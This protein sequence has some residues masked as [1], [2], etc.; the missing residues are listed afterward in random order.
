MLCIFDDNVA[1]MRRGGLLMRKLKWAVSI[2]LVLCM[3]SV[4]GIAV[5]AEDNTEPTDDSSATVNSEDTT[6]SSSEASGTDESGTD[7]SSTDESGTDESSTG[8][9]SEDSSEEPSDDPNSRTIRI[10]GDAAGVDVFFNGSEDSASKYKATVG[11]TVTFKV[12]VKDNYTLNSIKLFGVSALQPNEDGVYSFS[13]DADADYEYTIK[14][15]AT[16]KEPETSDDNSGENSG[17]SSDDNS[18]E[19]S[20]NETSEDDNKCPLV[21]TITGQGSVTSGDQEVKCDGATNTETIYLENGVATAVKIKPAYGYSLAALYLDGAYHVASENLTLTITE[22]TTLSITFS[23]A[24]VTPTTYKVTMTVMTDGGYISASGQT[25]NKGYPQEVV[26]SAGSSLPINVYPANDYEL[27]SFKV[28]NVTQ[29]LTNGSYTLASVGSDVSI[30]VSFKAV[31]KAKTA[32]EASD[33]TWS[34]G[35]DGNIHVNL[36]TYTNVGKS[37]FDKINSLSKDTA[38][39]CVLETEFVRWYIPCG[40]KISGVSDDP[41]QMVVSLNANGSY[42]QTIKASIDAQDDTTIFNYYEA[43]KLPEFPEETL[44]SFNLADYARTYAGNNVNLM[45]KSENS[46][47]VCGNG[48]AEAEGWTSAMNYKNSRYMVVRIE[49]AENYSVTANAGNGG[50]ITPSGTNSVLFK[51]NFSVTVSANSG[52]IISAVYVDNVPVAGAAGSFEFSYVLESITGN[53]EI[54]AEF[55]PSGSDYTIVNN[56]A[57]TNDN[58][59]TD[60]NE[61]GSH[62]GLIVAL[63]IIFVAVAGAAVLFIIKWRQEKF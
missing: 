39:Y 46:L 35:S 1:V 56:V 29:N 53:H 41:F 15:S 18:G 49:T 22:R 55:I 16:N 50:R 20:G 19:N 2:L 24:V 7:E 21:I 40:S 5:F 48:T 14:V 13:V 51:S 4:F 3:L 23:T 61:S 52:Y 36:G 60:E 47:V 59:S 57:V 28:N 63:V 26:V 43:S 12:T 45:V 27:D 42:Y 32:V 33:F 25:A 11:D 54:H 44:A 8:E 58:M 30:S 62:T 34:A 6:E 37:V 17:E 31:Q 38:K 9:P 10:T